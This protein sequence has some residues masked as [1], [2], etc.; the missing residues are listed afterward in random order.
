ML[1][2]EL[3]FHGR[4]TR[5]TLRYRAL[6]T[7][8]PF[9]GGTTSLQP[10]RS[11]RC[12]VHASNA[13]V[14]PRRRARIMAECRTLL[15]NATTFEFTA[16]GRGH[17]TVQSR[18]RGPRKTGFTAINVNAENEASIACHTWIMSDRRRPFVFVNFLRLSRRTFT[19]VSLFR[20]STTR[21][22]RQHPNRVENGP[23]CLFVWRQTVGANAS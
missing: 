19:P 17:R 9:S 20:L 5:S 23:S 1:H 6:P 10:K 3:P 8:A 21:S 2:D 14:R 18:T 12:Y 11:L 22:D 16:A 4:A 15:E 7:A 13:T